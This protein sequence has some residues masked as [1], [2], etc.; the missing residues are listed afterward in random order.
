[1]G[2][3][4]RAPVSKVP[5]R[6]GPNGKHHSFVITFQVCALPTASRKPLDLPSPPDPQKPRAAIGR[7]GPIMSRASCSADAA[8]RP[9]RH[10]R[11]TGSNSNLS[12]FH[13]LKFATAPW[14]FGA[15][16]PLLSW[17]LVSSRLV[18]EVELLDEL[19]AA[20][21][22]VCAHCMDGCR[23]TLCGSATRWTD[24]DPKTA[25][26]LEHHPE[27]GIRHSPPSY[28]FCRGTPR[29]WQR[30]AFWYRPWMRQGPIPAARS[31]AD[32]VN[33]R[34]VMARL[35]FRA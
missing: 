22:H 19:G 18:D 34:T 1:M 31:R 8:P 29:P 3:V 28:D 20:R 25:R 17:G 14:P 30:W 2:L 16:G 27:E 11:S 32:M 33:R 21:V 12:L 24:I 5:G 13:A 10:W 9:D 15:E 6:T 7:E 23:G 26:L 35:M 4:K